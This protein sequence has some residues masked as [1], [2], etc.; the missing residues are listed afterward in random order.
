MRE[1]GSS[2]RKG[3]I[4]KL[5]GI[6]IN[7]VDVPIY[8]T[9]AATDAPNFYILITNQFEQ[10]SSLKDVFVN[11]CSIT[12]DTVTK[13]STTG[14]GSLISELI[15]NQVSN[16]IL[17]AST[18]NYIDLSTDGFKLISTVKEMS[19]SL[20]TDTGTIKEYRKILIF[21]HKIQQTVND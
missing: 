4:S 5:A 3:Y 14:G 2:L 7:G 16:R 1:I 13:F 15:A 18:A 11:D 19:K 10:D 9:F 20:N 12:V 6:Q 21:K 8:D 17:P